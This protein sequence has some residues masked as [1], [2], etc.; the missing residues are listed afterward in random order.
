MFLLY[1]TLTPECMHVCLFS[2]HL[3]ENSCTTQ[4]QEEFFYKWNHKKYNILWTLLQKYMLTDF[5]ECISLNN[6]YII[7]SMAHSLQK[8]FGLGSI[9]LARTKICFLLRK[10]AEGHGIKLCTSLGSVQH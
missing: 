2:F 4:V 3:I 6:Q 5:K 8:L 10:I 9:V 1:F 7:R